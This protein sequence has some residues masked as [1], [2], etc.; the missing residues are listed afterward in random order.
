MLSA[1]PPA[2]PAEQAEHSETVEAE[3]REHREERS[4][5]PPPPRGE[6]SSRPAA[7]GTDDRVVADMTPDEI[8]IAELPEPEGEAAPKAKTIEI[9]RTGAGT[10][11]VTVP[12]ESKVEL[13]RVQAGTFGDR[14]NAVRLVDDIRRKGYSAEAFPVRIEDRT[15]YRVRVGGYKTHEGAKKLAEDLS[16]QGFAPSIVRVDRDL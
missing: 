12:V 13:Y 10:E 15:M 11:Q 6:A 14:E 2:R 8:S 4:E 16:R 9:V 1:P 7:T 3:V 5:P